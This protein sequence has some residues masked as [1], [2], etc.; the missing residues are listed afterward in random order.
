ME[1]LIDL[2]ADCPIYEQ[3]YEFIK[4]EIKSGQILPD[5]KLP[6]T[7][8][9]SQ[10]LKISR[11]TVVNAYEQLSAEGYLRSR[12]G[13]GYIVNKLDDMDI[14]KKVPDK[15]ERSRYIISSC[16]TDSKED[17]NLIDFSPTKIDSK[18]FPYASWRSIARKVFSGSDV[19]TAGDKQGEYGLRV[20]IADYLHTAR[21]VE[22]TP[23]NIIIGA[24]SEYL[25]LLLGLL[26]GRKRIALENPGYI[27]ARQ[28]FESMEWDIISVDM[29]D[30][31]M[32][33]DKLE[34]GKADICYLMPA[35]QYPTGVI[36]PI[37]R[38]R[39]LIAWSYEKSGRYIIEDDYDS[40]F[41]FVGK[42]IPAMQGLDPQK[43]IYIGTFSKSVAP[44]IRVAY[45]VLPDEL[46]KEYES[47][48]DFFS[49]T[50]PRSDQDILEIFIKEGYFERHLNRMRT[51]Y[52]IKRDILI[53]S[54]KKH[55]P[56]SK[57]VENN[58]GLHIL[59]TLEDLSEKEILDCGVKAGVRF[60]PISV[61]YT[62][63]NIKKSTVLVGFAS[64]TED[65]IKKGI[66]DF[67]ELEERRKES[68]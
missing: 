56:R 6:S 4:N 43:V 18:S 66:K 36:M 10:S 3:I 9:L 68:L 67:S 65:D 29:D 11:T 21:R 7:R 37:K 41:R 20:Q 2:R 31:G 58:S 60:Y 32:D 53:E 25:I 64:L 54:V 23:Q 47:R 44:A 1:L 17:D 42:P 51:N 27:K 33:I 45:M 63:K 48:L 50:V 14:L 39:E 34:S 52:R 59:M 30:E 28:I 5:T 46:I 12:G 24:G 22:C 16:K 57:V 55:L 19:F 61:F 8:R 38:R 26:L 62:G 35:N 13:S 49:C 40:E 15:A